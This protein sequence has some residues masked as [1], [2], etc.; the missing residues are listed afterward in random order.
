MKVKKQLIYPSEGF[1][2]EKSLASLLKNTRFDRETGE[3]TLLISDP[4]LLYEI[5]T[6]PEERGGYISTRINKKL[7]HIRVEYFL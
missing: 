5:E 6:F 1:D 2:W 7:L 4:N 3:I